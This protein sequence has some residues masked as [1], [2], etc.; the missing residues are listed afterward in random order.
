[1][2]RQISFDDMARKWG[3]LIIKHR[4]E[5]VTHKHLMKLKPDYEKYFLYERENKLLCLGAFIGERLVGYSV[6]FTNLPH[7]HYMDLICSVNDV[8]YLDEKYRKS[9]LGLSLIRET[10][11]LS[12]LFGC[13]MISWHAKEATS[14]LQLLP[15]MGYDIQEVILNKEL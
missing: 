3:G 9:T 4:E 12:K 11:R 14:L 2:I 6:T 8:I 13:K 5:V 15:N 1:M 10:E 7:M